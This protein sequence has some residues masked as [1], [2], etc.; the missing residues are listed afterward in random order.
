MSAIWLATRGLKDM[1][2]VTPSLM[3]LMNY[4]LLLYKVGALCLESRK[5]F[6]IYRTHKTKELKKA[7]QLDC[8]L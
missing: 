2:L 4:V 6:Y 7:E 1:R 5:Y 8:T 3:T